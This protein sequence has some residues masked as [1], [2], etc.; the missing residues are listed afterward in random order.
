MKRFIALLLVVLTL[1][2]LAACANNPDDDKKPLSSSSSSSSS[3]SVSDDDIDSG[4]FID[5]LLADRSKVSSGLP[6]EFNGNGT[7]VTI[8]CLHAE[9]SNGY[10]ADWIM[11]EDYT[12]DSM[13]NVL[14]ER[15]LNIE[16]NFGVKLSFVY[17]DDSDGYVNSRSTVIKA[18]L[19]DIDILG[20][21]PW[22]IELPIEGVC[23]DLMD[24]PYLDFSR[25]WWLTE[26]N[27]SFMLDGSLLIGFGCATAT[28]LF[29]GTGVTFFNMDLAEDF[30]IEDLFQVAREGR[31]T[32]DYVFQLMKDYYINVN[33]DPEQSTYGYFPSASNAFYNMGGSFITID[34]NTNEPTFTIN[35]ATHQDLFDKIR[36]MQLYYGKDV[37]DMVWATEGRILAWFTN[38]RWIESDTGFD[39]DIGILPP[40][41]YDENSVYRGAGYF[42]GSCIALDTR[43]EDTAA[44]VLEA[45]AYYGW[46]DCVPRYYETIIKY[47]YSSNQQNAEMLDLMY[48]NLYYDPI[49]MYCRDVTRN[50][51][52]GYVDYSG[53]FASYIKRKAAVWGN[54]VK[55]SIKDYRSAIERLKKSN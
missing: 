50:G 18:G 41:K 9:N 28:S 44:L 10:E 21:A 48:S 11:A 34:E 4:S 54:T 19:G 26:T 5:S 24:L 51:I 43:I 39:F 23:L 49:Y 3:S 30:G 6:T 31:W 52:D 7:T 46:R 36:D 17:L 47:K 25:S 2:P 40:L 12:K 14:Y 53:E 38:L 13:N 32:Y 15:K 8:D 42:A 45:L 35:T 16:D 22:G 20:V 55:S 29:S 33:D 27:N 37:V 1:L